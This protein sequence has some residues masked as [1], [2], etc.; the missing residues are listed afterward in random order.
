MTTRGLLRSLLPL[1]ALWLAAVGHSATAAGALLPDATRIKAAFD[2][3]DTSRNGAINAA[4]WDHASFA[5]FRSFDKN[6][7]DHIDREELKATA[8]AP[9]TFRRI[10][11]DQ[12]S[13]LNAGEFTEHRRALLQIADIDRNEYLSPVEYEL[14]IVMERIGWQDTNQNGRIELSELTVSLQKA[15]D[16]LDLDRDGT[17][18]MSEAAFMRP[19]A[20]TRSDTNRDGALSREEF[21]GGYRTELISG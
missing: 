11:L 16:E 13:R 17:L 7:D 4:E 15:F 19:A 10:D 18:Q 12:D 2:A 6:N 5:L 8:I 20:L 9:D 21:V 1:A 14:F 3:V